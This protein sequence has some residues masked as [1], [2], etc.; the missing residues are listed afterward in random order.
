MR[1]LFSALCHLM[2]LATFVIGL[3]VILLWGLSGNSKNCKV[4]LVGNKTILD[5]NCSIFYGTLYCD[6]NRYG[7]WETFNCWREK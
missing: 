4:N 3:F 1:E 7:S 2:C 5:K 6:N